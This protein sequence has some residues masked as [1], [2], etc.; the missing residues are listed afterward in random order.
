MS[1]TDDRTMLRDFWYLVVPASAVAKGKTLA[2]TVL[3][4]AILL[5]RTP[6]DAV[7]AYV[8]ACPHRGMPMRHGSFDGAH[9]RCCYHGWA[10]D[11]RDG[12]CTEIPALAMG[13]QTDP[14]RFRLRSYPCRE[15]QGNIWVYMPG[16]RALPDSLPNVPTVPGFEGEGPQVTTTMRFPSNGDIAAMGFCDP[17]HPA[18]VH[19]S[20]WWKSKSALSLRPKSKTFEPI[21]HG[22]RMKQHQ[23]KGGANPY[24]LLGTDVRVDVTVQLP[25]LRIEHIR[26]TKHSACV[27]A[28]VTPVSETETDVH[29]C[30]YWTIPWLAPVRPL[31]AWMARD[32]LRQDMDMAAKLAHGPSTPPMLFVGDADKQVAW[33]LR[34]KREYIAS[35][36]EKREFVNPIQDQEL[37]WRS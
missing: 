9:L 3:G 24:R 29:Y 22:F 17:A 11:A 10:F 6:S 23:L 32:F 2:A 7:F 30:V 13:D 26:G 1:V 21:E 12:R 36:A 19:T 8:D 35:K 4:E 25:G 16:G 28:A 15:V 18:F 37:H 34:L 20:R 33:F 14:T 5:V 27:L 31:A